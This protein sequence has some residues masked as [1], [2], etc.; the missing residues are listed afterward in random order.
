VKSPALPVTC[1][2]I[3]VCLE[4]RIDGTAASIFGPPNEETYLAYAHA[5]A[6]AAQHPGY[7]QEKNT[8]NAAGEP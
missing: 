8:E 4:Q 7:R 3:T 2:D 5:C 1:T 6:V